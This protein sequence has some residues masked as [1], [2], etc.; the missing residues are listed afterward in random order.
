[1]YEL[2]HSPAALG[3]AEAIMAFEMAGWQT[4]PELACPGGIPFSNAVENTDRNTVTNAPAAELALQLYHITHNAAV[5][6]VRGDGLR[7]GA[8]LPAAAERPVR[9]P[10]PPARRRR[11]DALEL[12]PGH[13]DRRRHAALPGHRRRRIPVPGAPDRARR[14]S[15]TSRRSGWRRKIRSSRRSTSAT[16]CT[17]TRSPTTRPGPRSRRPTSTTPGSTC[18]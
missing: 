7:M 5:P 3:S 8:R 16:S 6:A 2:T 18:A 15:P 1:M 4:E 9:R 12:Q 17:W 10:H 14:R 11:T 13:D